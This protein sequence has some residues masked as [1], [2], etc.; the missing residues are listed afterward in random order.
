[1][2]VCVGGGGGGGW[3]GLMF[4]ICYGM[5]EKNHSWCKSTEIPFH[6]NNPCKTRGRNKNG[7]GGGGGE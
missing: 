2:C 1:M 3:G 6:C 7:R 4:L 5:R